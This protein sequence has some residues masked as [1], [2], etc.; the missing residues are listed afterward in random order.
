M[1]RRDSQQRLARDQRDGDQ[2]GRRRA[3]GPQGAS[4]CRFPWPTCSAALIDAV[5]IYGSGGFT[6]YTDRQLREQFAAWVEQGIP[7]VKMK[8]GRDPAPIP[9][10]SAR[11]ARRSAPTPSCSSTPTAPTGRKQALALATWL[12][13]AR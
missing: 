5:P 7:R 1:V 10:A 2:R 9:A 8:I 12:A 6:S 4:C 3:V 13:S 11:R